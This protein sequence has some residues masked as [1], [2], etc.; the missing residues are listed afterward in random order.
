MTPQQGRRSCLSRNADWRREAGHI[1]ALAGRTG[2]AA[3]QRELLL[4]EAKTADA[5]ADEWLNAA[6]ELPEASGRPGL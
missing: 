1:R 2:L 5:C 4:R 6:I 3:H